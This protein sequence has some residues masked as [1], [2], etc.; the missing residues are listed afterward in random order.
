MSELGSW[1]TNSSKVVY[2][3]PFLEILSDEVTMPNGQ[4]GHYGWMRSKGEAV[5]VVPVTDANEVLLVQQQR[6]TIGSRATIECVAGG[7]KSGETHLDAG[8]RELLEETGYSTANLTP[9]YDNDPL[10]YPSISKTHDPYKLYL[11]TG[12]THETE[13]LDEIDGIENV[14]AIPLS[15]LTDYL[16]A[17]NVVCSQSIASLFA[18]YAKLTKA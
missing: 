15:Q 8:H 9:V 17:G 6:Y 13:R 5:Y 18:A 10:I 3:T 16:L 1:Q 11:A 12:L 4:E 14:V 7:L 2:E